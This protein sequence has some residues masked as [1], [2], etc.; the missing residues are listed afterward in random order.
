MI[1]N[2]YYGDGA[3]TCSA[4]QC[5]AGWKLRDLSAIIGNIPG[6]NSAYISSNSSSDAEFR[7]NAGLNQ[8][9]YGL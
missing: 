1:G 3:D 9:Y 4:T 6:A 5:V 2:D 8:D 7:D